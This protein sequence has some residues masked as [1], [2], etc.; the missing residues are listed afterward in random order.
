MARY[1]LIE[2]NSGYIWGEAEA[3][4]PVAACRAV[5][6][7]IGTYA[8][9]TYEE[10]GANFQPAFNAG[11]YHV[12]EAPADFPKINNGRDGNAIDAVSALP[13]AAVVTYRV[14]GETL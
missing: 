14:A 8:S 10:R 11:A 12:Y 9:T 3:A 2:N 13:K 4:D 5:D 6:A 1:I 7:N